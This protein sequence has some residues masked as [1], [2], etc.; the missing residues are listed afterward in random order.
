[1]AKKTQCGNTNACIDG[2][3]KY[4]KNTDRL[5]QEKMMFA[6]LKISIALKYCSSQVYL[7]KELA[8][9]RYDIDMRK[10]LYANVELHR[11][12]TLVSC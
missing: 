11:F 8:E 3:I 4:T 9:T 2:I 10:N 5:I 1:M 7:V 12:G 6:A